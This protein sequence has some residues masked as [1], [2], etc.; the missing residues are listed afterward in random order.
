MEATDT[1]IITQTPLTFSQLH[2]QLQDA[3]TKIGYSS[4]FPVQEQSF[5]PVLRGQDVVVQSKTGSGK[6]AAFAM[7]LVQKWLL[8]ETP[9]TPHRPTAL[10]LVPTRELALQVTREFHRLSQNM[11]LH[12]AA[13]YGGSPMGK[14][15]E[16]LQQGV[17]IVIGT[18]GRVLDH[19]KR[20]HLKLDALQTLVLDEADEM[21]SRGFLEEVTQII[22]K[23]PSS[24]QQILLSATLP[25]EIERLC[26]RTMVQPVWIR[27]S[28]DLV[29]PPEISHFYYLVS[30]VGR[31]RD[32]LRVLDIEQPKQAIIF[33]NTREETEEV[34]SFLRNRGL[35]AQ[36]ISSNLTQRE[37]EEVMAKVKAH[38]LPYLVA[39]DIAARGIDVPQLSHVIN[40]TFPESPEVY[41]HRTGRT[42]RAGESGKAISLIG[43]HELA[44]F[45]TFKLTY[46]I[47]PQEQEFP[48]LEEL[49]RLREEKYV[50]QL[51]AELIRQPPE[52][53]LS[54][55]KKLMTTA[56]GQRILA[57]AL[58][59]YL[60]PVADTPVA[61]GVGETL[62]NNEPIPHKE[63]EV[64]KPLRRKPER[65]ALAE[66]EK[67]IRSP[68]GKK[69]K[70][71]SGEEQ[72]VL[73]RRPEKKSSRTSRP[74]KP[75]LTEMA[76][77]SEEP[78][79][80]SE[81]TEYWEAW[82]DS[83]TPAPVGASKESSGAAPHVIPDVEKDQVESADFPMDS[84]FS[85]TKVYLNLGRRHGFNKQRLERLLQEHGVSNYP[86]SVRF[87]YTH[88]WVPEEK[89]E[90]TIAALHG[91]AYKRRSLVCERA[92]TE[93][94]VQA[95]E[96]LV[97]SQE[98]ASPL[99]VEES[100]AE[101]L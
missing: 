50:K 34:A 31:V 24:K 45:Y 39:T 88:L 32:L 70:R 27:L 17:H 48:S 86:G 44:S 47:R 75:Y 8:Q 6:T 63:P 18:P 95:A 79:E 21:L 12:V 68:R 25:P 7:P 2:P 64:E 89:V 93:S 19:I 14:Q 28:T 61:D 85:G 65:S 54:L 94:G 30:G 56:E 46:P 49:Q 73:S 100:P 78:I 15:T 42:G 53:F 5:F 101:T 51:Q 99:T 52:V 13:I 22:E 66:K 76:V 40:F 71:E 1:E 83:K 55:A 90:S 3:L 81:G 96:I 74:E 16:E 43:P 72:E 60:T 62:K 98:E 59:K 69:E 33:C 82:V 23:T 84:S 38:A 80:I 29:S 57:V 4:F 26:E 11:G 37:R 35:H 92:R 87:A 41:I 9:A 77:V 97:P 91:K 36:A 10:V 58:E 67:N 20:E